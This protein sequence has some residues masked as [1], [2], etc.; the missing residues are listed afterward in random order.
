MIVWAFMAS[1]LVGWFCAEGSANRKPPPRSAQ[2][3]KSLI[4]S[5]APTV[6]G[7]RNN[8]SPTDDRDFSDRFKKTLAIRSKIKRAR[9]I[10]AVADDLSAAQI[11]SAIERVQR[12][13]IAERQAILVVLI[14][15]WAELEPEAAFAY[16]QDYKADDNLV[17][18][19]QVT[20]NWARANPEAAQEAIA[21]VP[22]GMLRSA[23]IA[24]I[25]EALSETDPEQAFRL[26]E[27]TTTFSN[28]IDTLFKNWS[29]KDPQIAGAHALKL[30]PGF[31]RDAA[32]RATALTWAKADV[33]GAL[34]WTESLPDVDA[35]G[36]LGNGTP[37]GNI[38]LAWAEEDAD[39]ALRWIEELP[40]GSRKSGIL[41]TLCSQYAYQYDDPNFAARLISTAPPGS[42]RNDAWKTFTNTWAEV[43][44][45]GATAWAKQ[46]PDDVRNTVLPVLARST[47]HTDPAAA[48]ELASTLSE[49][50]KDDAIKDVISTWAHADPSSAAAWVRKQPPKSAL[51]EAVAAGWIMKDVGAA[52][53][54]INTI[55]GG[56]VKDDVL[57]RVVR[58]IQ[59]E[60][61]RIAIAWIEGIS[62][63]GKREAAYKNLSRNWLRLD[64]TAAR[65]WIES[66]PLPQAF[67]D[68]MLGQSEK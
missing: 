57:G 12:T 53:E 28:P 7:L 8:F 9:A 34:N 19:G 39:S 61:P 37:V 56:P 32:I 48:I 59:G 54:W 4:Q 33:L 10:A 24:G 68:E 66:A 31:Q 42:A 27:K 18:I 52:T 50:A 20:K 40:E 17:L 41:N 67:K 23:G 14:S 15:R 60:N 36:R 43:D 11:R 13:R 26:A 64:R 38:V 55:E 44:L 6:D 49:A 45:A 22:E 1:A 63:E 65:A 30:P 25:I 58:R 35:I 3:E 16:A 51:L 5:S 47:V 62:E 29:E 2:I 21:K 46:Q